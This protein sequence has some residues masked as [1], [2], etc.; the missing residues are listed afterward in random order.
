[1]TDEE[2]EHRKSQTVNFVKDKL[3]DV[4]EKDQRV[5]H[6]VTDVPKVDMPWPYVL[7]FLNCVLPG[8]IKILYRNY[9]I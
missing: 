5:W 9:V 3:I 2:F 1:M 4:D 6:L 7:F 8:K